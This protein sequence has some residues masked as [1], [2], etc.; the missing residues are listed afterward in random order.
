MSINTKKD[1]SRII[2]AQKQSGKTI[3]AYCTEHQLPTSTFYANKKKHN[4]ESKSGFTQV[5]F[6][7]APSSDKEVTGNFFLSHGNTSL[8][9][10][11]VDADFIVSLI[12]GLA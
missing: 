5:R 3:Q 2:E 10:S 7:S 9:F 4:V 6:T 11:G 8:T 12:K 1:W